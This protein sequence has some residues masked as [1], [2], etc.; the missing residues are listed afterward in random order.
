APAPPPLVP[1]RVDPDRGGRRRARPR[2][3]ASRGLV[4]PCPREALGRAAQ[5]LRRRPRDEPPG[6]LLRGRRGDRLGARA[7]R[8]RDRLVRR[9]L[10]LAARAL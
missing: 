8:P 7:A 4:R 2:R 1:D 3:R 10:H 5:L 6:V 9:A